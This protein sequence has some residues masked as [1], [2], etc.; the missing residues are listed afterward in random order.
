MSVSQ[1]NAVGLN[2]Y[3]L[4]RHLKKRGSQRETERGYCLVSQA[5]DEYD[6]PL[7]GIRQHVTDASRI[8]CEGGELTCEPELW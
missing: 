1:Y 3:M 6:A 2:V 7:G 5:R 8:E 4:G